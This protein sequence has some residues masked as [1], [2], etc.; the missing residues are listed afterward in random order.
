[1]VKMHSSKPAT[2]QTRSK[3]NIVKASTIS[4][5]D[6]RQKRVKKWKQ[7][8]EADIEEDIIEEPKL[9]EKNRQGKKP[10]TW[11]FTKVR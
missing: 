8:V 6:K 3:G 5:I 10:K 9:V 4:L 1:M 2:R 11:K 7:R